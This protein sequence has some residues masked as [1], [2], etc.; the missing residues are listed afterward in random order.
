MLMSKI[1]FD[2]ILSLAYIHSMTVVKKSPLKRRAAT[3]KQA[4]QAKSKLVAR[5]APAPAEV[6]AKPK[7]T[8]LRLKSSLQEGLT[9]LQEAVKRPINKLVNE[10]VEE[11]L[12]RQTER[13]ERDLQGLLSRIKAVRNVDPKFKVAVKA[14]AEAE[15]K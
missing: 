7:A 11:F 1:D 3:P 9:V 14:F 10:A 6:H 15:S 13:V 4:M 5:R 2:V 12:V 8:T